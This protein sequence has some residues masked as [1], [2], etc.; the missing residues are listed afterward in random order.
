MKS[1]RLGFCFAILILSA[2]FVGC[3]GTKGC[4]SGSGSTGGA[5]SGGGGVQSS[6]PCAAVASGGSGGTGTTVPGGSS[7]ALLYAFNGTDIEA[8]GLT[9]NGTFGHLS[10]F[11]SPTVTGSGADNMLIVNKKFVYIPQ[12]STNN[13]EGF[14]I[15]RATGGLTVIPGSP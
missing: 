7:F 12:S 6:S 4:P 5:S 13:V 1:A 3:G 2:S 10:P 9:S 11:T 15:N 8:L 14:A